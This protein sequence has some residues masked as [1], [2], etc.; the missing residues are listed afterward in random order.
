MIP[1]AKSVATFAPHQGKTE[2]ERK[3]N[4]RQ[5]AKA[6]ANIPHAEDEAT[7]AL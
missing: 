6:M 2:D 7:L 3:D 5:M 4:A 1:G